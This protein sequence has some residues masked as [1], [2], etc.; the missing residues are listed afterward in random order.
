[1]RIVLLSLDPSV[2]FA[3]PKGSSVHLR[4]VADALLRTGNTVHVVTGAPGPGSV[5][6]P[7]LE[8]GLGVTAV[9]DRI[10]EDD[11]VRRLEWFAPDLVIER[12]TPNAPQGAR[13]A[14]RLRVTHLYEVDAPLEEGS[15]AHNGAADVAPARSAF[16]AGFAAST[17]AVVISDEAA[18]WVR[19]LAPPDYRI[20]MVPHGPHRR[21]FTDPDPRWA[22]HVRRTIGEPNGFRVGFVGA[23]RP[24]QDLESLVRAM[25]LLN[26]RV[27]CRLVL[28]GDGP[29]RNR[30][31]A[32]AHGSSAKVTLV[33]RVPQEAVPAY[34]AACD[35][36]A[37]PYATPA[38]C[39]SPLKLVEAMAAG[40][41]MAVSAT[42]TC[43]RLLRDDVNALLVPCGDDAAMA[44]ALERLAA[45]PRLRER[46]GA[47]ARRRALDGG[48]SEDVVAGVVELARGLSAVGGAA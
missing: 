30:L 37:I 35:A 14:A 15:G 17:A 46:L 45:D 10:G 26:R 13:A 34:L 25:G 20:E 33:G 42:P 47:A 27:D 18:A 28:V 1:M 48:A 2:P 40:R 19:S 36:V 9:P 16:R 41:A 44:A 5:P 39:G 29:T 38:V 3:G 6:A 8:S 21:F 4:A 7:L 11:L 22:A 12:L 23:F 32:E 31:L 43:A 24:S